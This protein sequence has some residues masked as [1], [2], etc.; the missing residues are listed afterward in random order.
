MIKTEELKLGNYVNL[1]DGSVDDDIRKVAGISKNK[2]EVLVKG[3]EQVKS[4][5]PTKIIYAI[6]LTEE[7]ILKFGFIKAENTFIKIENDEWKSKF[8]ITYEDNIF[9][10]PITGYWYGIYT[11]HQL[12]NIY[13]SL[14]QEELEIKL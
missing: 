4:Y 8:I 3:C 5:L 13:F 11:I 6:P 7:V 10:I 1:S 14:T 2:I 9:K 12:Q